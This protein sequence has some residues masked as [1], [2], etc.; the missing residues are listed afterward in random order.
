MDAAPR[1]S[2]RHGTAPRASIAPTRSGFTVIELVIVLSMI[3]LM[4]AIA[5]PRFRELSN[6]LENAARETGGFF[7]QAR[8]EAMTTTSAYRVIS[9]SSRRLRAEY[10]PS[11]NSEDD[12]W[13]LDRGLPFEL[14]ERASFMDLAADST[15][16]CF[17]T[18]GVGDANPVLTIQRAGRIA[19]VEVFLGGGVTVTPFPTEDEE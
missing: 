14:R 17:D 2:R 3:G 8:A 4:A 7:R 1:T 19:E 9:N 18:R 5:L 13:T 6:E 15:L 16:I 10:A 12:E 11:C